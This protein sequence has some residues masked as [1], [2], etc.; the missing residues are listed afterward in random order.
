MKQF[1]LLLFFGVISFT[2]GAQ[3]TVSGVVTDAMNEPL[4][5]ITVAVE[6]TASGTITDQDGKYN[7]TVPDKNST[8]LFSF[9]GFA[10]QKITV[11]GRSVINVT[12]LEDVA[13]L[14]EVVV[15]GYGTQK[16]VNV[17]GAVSSINFEDQAVS[18]PITSVS[19]SLAG[20]SAGLSVSQ[21]SG[22]PG[23]DGATLRIRGV[24]TLNDNSP[25]ILIDGMIGSI[26]DVNPNDI[27]S[28]SILKDGASA[29]IY[30]ARAGAGVILITTKNGNKEGK[31]TIT[32]SGR[33]SVMNPMNL[34]KT[35]NN[36]A[37][38]MEYTNE[39]NWQSGGTGTTFDPVTDIQLW[40]EKAKDPNGL[41]EYGF[42]NYVAY[43]N[44]NWLEEVY[45]KN[46][47]KQEHNISVAGNSSN[48]RYLLSM[49]YVDNRGW[50]TILV[51]SVSI[52]V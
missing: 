17:T 23:S 26:D 40:R 19:A 48:A 32:Y 27:A 18:R 10:T 47:I 3:V 14:D 30:G 2:A 51:W 33:V 44:V 37:D 46:S 7:I 43:P 42:P 52:C 8:L 31:T 45:N 29:A 11:N 38:F 36:Y 5:G 21:G 28:I 41:N 35:V 25:L 34:P 22:Q 39:A 9:I 6:N 24:G 12:L 50:L 16:K 1:L 13:M 4:P 20:L 15:V 49:G